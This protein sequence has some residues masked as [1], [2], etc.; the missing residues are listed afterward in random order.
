MLVVDHDKTVAQRHLLPGYLSCLFVEVS[1]NSVFAGTA[2]FSDASALDKIS[3][4]RSLHSQGFWYSEESDQVVTGA[5]TIL[6]QCRTLHYPYLLT[7]R[8]DELET[9]S[10]LYTSDFYAWEFRAMRIMSLSPWSRSI[11]FVVAHTSM[12]ASIGS[13]AEDVLRAP[14]KNYVTRRESAVR[15]FDSQ[16]HRR[17]KF[18]LS[19]FQVAEV[20]STLHVFSSL[21]EDYLLE[22]FRR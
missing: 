16:I 4:R 21:H 7:A 9:M 19:I 11:A 13:S 8:D 12:T 5:P 14:I 17:E 6:E 22:F 10:S 2:T 15:P 1:G 20:Q 3:T 18:L